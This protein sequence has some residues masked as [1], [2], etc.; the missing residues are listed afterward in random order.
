MWTAPA[1]ATADQTV[2]LTLTVTDTVGD[3]DFSTDVTV[4]ANQPPTVMLAGLI[5][6]V[7]GGASQLELNAVVTDPEGDTLTYAWTSD[8][9]GSFND[10][11]A[12][13]NDLWTAPDATDADQ[14]VMLTLTATDDGAGAR[15]A[16]DSA[17]ITVRAQ[18]QLAVT[19]T[20][21][22]TT[23]NGGGTVM[24]STTVTGDVGD[25]RYN[26]H[27]DGFSS[28]SI[29]NPVWTAGRAPFSDSNVT[30]SLTVFDDVTNASAL[31]TESRCGEPGAGGVLAGGGHHARRGRRGGGVVDPP[32]PP[33]PRA[34]R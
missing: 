29:P 3:T 9:G 20:A 26:W 30:L 27:G 23:V 2:T 8:G 13:D 11:G 16:S 18:S 28:R 10:A 34:T 14:T 1:A 4:R 15:S 7:R 5:T 6:E 24:L 31:V 12:L 17:V 22:P 33:T 19:I 25:V 21:D 32:R